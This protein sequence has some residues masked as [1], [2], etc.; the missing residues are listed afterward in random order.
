MRAALVLVIALALAACARA[1]QPVAVYDAGS[2]PAGRL[3]TEIR[4]GR[5]IITQTRH[6]LPQDVRVSMDCAAC[7]LDGG[8]RDHAGSFVGTYATFPQW[9][10]RAHRFITLQDRVAECFLYSMNGRPPSYTSREMIAVVAYI[11]WLSRGT[12]T[13]RVDM[14]PQSFKIPLPAGA[15]NVHEGAAIF[16]QR[17]STCHGANGAGGGPFPPLWGDASFND[18]AGMAH[19]DR[20]TGFVYYNMPQ[21]APH[22]LT[23]QQAY[24]V[25][26]F[27]LSHERPAFGKSALVSFPALRAGYF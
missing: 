21:N 15:P 11:A 22:T 2:L 24:D 19:I 20:M 7:H 18:G 1:A 4:Y 10:K 27:V 8:T 23:P 26:G 25:A 14:T 17:C 9:N 5:E 16:S 3:G 13:M 12:P 6:V